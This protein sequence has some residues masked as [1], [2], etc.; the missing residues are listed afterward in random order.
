M[1]LGLSY[2]PLYPSLGQ[3]LAPYTLHKHLLI[4]QLSEKSKRKHVLWKD[5]A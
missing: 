2:S 4:N 5:Y 1:A 3:D